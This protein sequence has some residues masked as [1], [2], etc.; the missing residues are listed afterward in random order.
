MGSTVAA[1]VY[2]PW[3]QQ[4]GAHFNPAVT[5][6]FFRLGK[7]EP[8]DA[9]FYILAHFVG[10]PAG[11]FGGL[12]VLGGWLAHPAVRY[13]VTVP[14]NGGA[15]AAFLAEL[16]ISF[17]LMALVLVAIN[18]PRLAPLAGGLVG[19]LVWVF[20][21]TEAPA[22]GASM[23]PARTVGSAVPAQVWTAVWVYFAAP[24]I[25]MLAA[26]EAYL[27][28]RGWRHVKSAKLHHAN[29]RRCIFRCDHHW[30]GATLE[31]GGVHGTRRPC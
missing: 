24:A 25:G 11:V 19:A 6:T 23:N 15:E 2:S 18:T 30:V 12:A 16:V 17:A 7:V 21:A 22:S 3:G 13:A 1:V 9:L 27:R 5:L 31:Q 14:G 10:A 20:I 4:S 28:L 8:W 26:A 29:G